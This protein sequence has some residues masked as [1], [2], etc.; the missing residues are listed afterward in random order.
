ML[1]NVDRI[2]ISGAKVPI[3][4]ICLQG[5]ATDVMQQKSLV[6]LVSSVAQPDK[7]GFRQ[8]T[9]WIEL[10]YIAQRR[11]SH[12]IWPNLFFE[13]IQKIASSIKLEVW[14]SSAADSMIPPTQFYTVAYDVES[15]IADS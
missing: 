13:Y 8:L 5:H 9:S 7:S 1:D 11:V 6:T 3:D 10:Q 12:Q 15:S 14:S 2:I 4:L